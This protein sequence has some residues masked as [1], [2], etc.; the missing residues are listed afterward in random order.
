MDRPGRQGDF[1]AIP[2]MHRLA[3]CCASFTI[4]LALLAAP[5]P[6]AMALDIEGDLSRGIAAYQ[7]GD[8][9]SALRWLEPV[10]KSGESQAQYMLGFMHQN[11]RGVPVDEEKGVRLFMQSAEQGN[12]YAQYALAASYRFGL[13]VEQDLLSAHR[14][15]LL[16]ERNGYDPARQIRMVIE[17]E[18]ALDQIARSREDTF[19]QTATAP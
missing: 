3:A 12:R 17:A 5:V 11:G 2:I 4:A 19:A 18:L 9:G 7:G 16:S 10:A 15:L 14:W 13:G 8:Y 6:A 1:R